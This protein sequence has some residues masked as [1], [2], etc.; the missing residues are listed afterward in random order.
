MS[1]ARHYYEPDK[2]VGFDGKEKKC[3]PEFVW[4]IPVAALQ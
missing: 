3:D 1:S 4:E 2:L